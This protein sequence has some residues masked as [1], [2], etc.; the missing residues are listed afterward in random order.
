MPSLNRLF[1]QDFADGTREQLVLGAAPLGLQVVG[2]V[3][4]HWL[5]SGLP[6]VLLAPLLAWQ[7]DLHFTSL[8]T[9]AASLAIGTQV[10]SL[11]GALG[12]SVAVGL[13]GGGVLVAL[14]MWTLYVPVR[15][16]GA[17]QVGSVCS[18]VG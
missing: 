5:L 17:G 4:A 10:I 12:A 2:K 16:F 6:L 7:F 1:E 13:R 14:L 3:I 15:I 9:L 18:G 11:M 8:P